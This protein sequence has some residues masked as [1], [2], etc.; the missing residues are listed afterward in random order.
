M[1]RFSFAR[2][3]LPALLLGLS[4][5]R[6]V[7]A[8]GPQEFALLNVAVVDRKG[9]ET[10]LA[11]FYRISG[12]DYFQ[13]YLGAAEVRIPYARVR[14]CKVSPPEQPGERMRAEFTLRSGKTVA[15]TFDEREGEQLFT[16]FAAFGKVTLYFRDIRS[17]KILGRTKHSDLPV[18]GPPARG[19]DVK[20]TDR[21]GVT[22]ELLNFHR[23]AGQNALPAL[24]GSA[25][26]TIPLRIVKH[27]TIT[28][29]EKTPTAALAVVLRDGTKVNGSLPVSEEATSFTGEAEFG[30][31]FIQLGD[32]RELEVH[33]VTPELRDLDP[34]EA[35]EGRE[36]R[37][38]RK[39]R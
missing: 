33:R 37:E 24:R 12:E 7:V 18:Y 38:E 36:A 10:E 14:A 16:G 39:Q 30:A 21:R 13:G 17:L 22:T 26:V 9:V 28:P 20:I 1:R 6:S 11:G 34:L 8:D 4:A 19:A 3:L 31:Y 25:A 5:G 35:I 29:A 23:A 32:I 15:A 27:L 2:S